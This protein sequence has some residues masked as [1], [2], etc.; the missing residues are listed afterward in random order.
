MYFTINMISF[1][2]T[3]INQYDQDAYK[4][5]IKK[6]NYSH[7]RC[8]CDSV[9]HFH[10]HATYSRYLQLDVNNAVLLTITRIKCESCNCTHALLPSIIVP[11]R[12]LSNPN[13]ISI[14]RSFLHAISSVLISSSTILHTIIPC[15]CNVYY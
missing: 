8:T 6:M 2:T 7:I 15:L 1:Q 5:D 11:Y 13:I 14:I 4:E 10:D 3:F 12:I 9:G